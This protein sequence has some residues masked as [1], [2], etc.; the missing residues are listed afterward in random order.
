MYIRLEKDSK[1]YA[2]KYNATAIH[3]CN[4]IYI[5]KKKKYEKKSKIA[6][7]IISNTK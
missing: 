4:T 2:S 5:T 6:V 3:Y 1:N 7:L